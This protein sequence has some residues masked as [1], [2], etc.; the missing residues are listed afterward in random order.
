MAES[1]ADNV[2]PK[3]RAQRGCDRCVFFADSEQGEYGI[4]VLWESRQAADDAASVVGPVLMQAMGRAN[5][6]PNI[7]L[8]ETYEP[9]K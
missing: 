1:I 6:D 9:K 3:I 4:V 8:F 2:V 7:R 5:A